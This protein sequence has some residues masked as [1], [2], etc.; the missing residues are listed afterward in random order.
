MQA[1]C[2]LGLPFPAG[3]T[4]LVAL[5][6]PSVVFEWDWHNTSSMPG[7]VPYLGLGTAPAGLL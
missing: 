2:L 7:R 6:S 3:G 5:F 1:T 4:A